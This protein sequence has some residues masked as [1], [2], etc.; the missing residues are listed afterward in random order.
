MN[1][2]AIIRKLRETNLISDSEIKTIPLKGGVSSDIFLVKDGSDRFVVKKARE[3]LNVKDD[4]FSDPKRNRVEREF[5]VFAGKLL[6]G[7]VP[8]LLYADDDLDFFVM[9]YLG[10]ADFSNWKALLLDGF[11]DENTILK[12]AV[13][14]ADL[15]RLTFKSEEAM[16]T[17]QKKSYF[18]TLRTDP[19]LVTTGER[20]PEFSEIFFEEADRLNRWSET[21]IHGD[22]SPKNILTGKQ[23][24]VLLDHEVAC[25]GDPAFDLA[26]ML[27]HLHLKMLWHT[28]R[29][30]QCKN[31]A[32]LF[33][34]EY[35][36]RMPT[37]LSEPIIQRTGKL[38]LLLMLARIDG[39][40]PVEYFNEPEK[41]FVRRFVSDH[42]K[43]KEFRLR[44]ISQNWNRKLQTKSF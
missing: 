18:K 37:E 17:F 33:W 39:K 16:Q 30:K 40:S 36:D 20:H 15:H 11:F 10:P 5:A 29:Q 9:E 34:M 41:A 7:A 31:P 13:L 23:R 25:F 35:A 22:F 28:V 27:N 1:R 42:L 19:Y 4:W 38:L 24:V 43:G 12:A 44:D 26:F 14:M 6:P 32:P 3:K 2:S 8:K 21:L